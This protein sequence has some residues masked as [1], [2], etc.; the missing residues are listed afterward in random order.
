MECPRC[1][2]VVPALSSY[3]EAPAEPVGLPLVAAAHA[4]GQ[5]LYA[6]GSCGGVFVDRAALYAIERWARDRNARAH[7]A[8]VALRAFAEA[9]PEIA[10]PRCDADMFSRRWG[11]ATLV[12]VDACPECGGVWL[13]GGELEQLEARSF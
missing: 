6:C 3:R 10:C 11:M 5:T 12:T 9:R 8:E 2:S 7:A 13:D 1:A 4:S